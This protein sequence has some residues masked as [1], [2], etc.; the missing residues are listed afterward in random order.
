MLSL[1]QLLA[2]L[3]SGDEPRAENAAVQFVSHGDEGFEALLMLT[4]NPNEDT[5]WWALRAISEF[6]TP[7]ASARLV[8]A[9]QDSS[10]AVQMCAAVGLRLH[11]DAKAVP[12]LLPLLESTDPLL[13]KVAGDA[14]SA[15]G[16]PA[17]Q[18][19]IQVIES[20]ESSHRAKL[21]AVRVLA[22]VKDTVAI[23]TLFKVSQEGSSMMQ[24]WAE[25]GLDNLGIGMVFFDPS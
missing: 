19:L 14:L 13:A 10:V 8:T 4:D 18:A 9:L 25:K 23:S 21:E 12:A 11:P 3:T 1:N 17:S 20:P 5:R 22:L 15:I 6:G 24:Y 7:E 2:D 16:K